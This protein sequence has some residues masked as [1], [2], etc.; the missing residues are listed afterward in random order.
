MFIQFNRIYQREWA[1]FTQYAFFT[2]L[3]IL[4]ILFFLFFL[5]CQRSVIYFLPWLLFE[6]SFTHSEW[7]GLNVIFGQCLC[8]RSVWYSTDRKY[9]IWGGGLYSSEGNFIEKESSILRRRT[10]LCYIRLRNLI[11]AWK[12]STDDFGRKRMNFLL[13]EQNTFRRTALQEKLF[14]RETFDSGFNFVRS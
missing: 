8:Y 11:N 9:D 1:Q 7:K 5:F 10:L 4:F 3:M 14:Q 2:S 6:V 12:L 13:T